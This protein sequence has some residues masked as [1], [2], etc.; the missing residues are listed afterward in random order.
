MKNFFSLPPS[1]SRSSDRCLSGHHTYIFI[2]AWL[3]Q[4]D[5]RSPTSQ[6]SLH[7]LLSC[8]FRLK[9]SVFQRFKDDVKVDV[10]HQLCFLSV[11]RALSLSHSIR[12]GNFI[13]IHLLSW[14][15]SAVERHGMLYFI[16]LYFSPHCCAVVFSLL[17]KKE[18]W[19]SGNWTE[20]HHIH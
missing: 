7:V 12:W 17:K 18:C 9:F 13:L 3:S 15:G 1:R 14:A 16:F 20:S 19:Q 10:E 5:Q 8:I 2:V 6:I 4:C 11:A